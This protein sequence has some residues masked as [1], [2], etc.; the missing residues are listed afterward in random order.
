MDFTL[1]D[2]PSWKAIAKAAFLGSQIPLLSDPPTSPSI[3]T[4]KSC[5]NPGLSCQSGGGI[6]SDSCCIN[7]PG[8]I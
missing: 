1:K 5:T 4:L 2:L 6:V 7:S 3:G 8:M